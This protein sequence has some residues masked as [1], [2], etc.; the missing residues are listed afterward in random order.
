M[1]TTSNPLDRHATHQ[2]LA[3]NTNTPACGVGSL[4]FYNELVVGYAGT[5]DSGNTYT[6]G[7]GYGNAVTLKVSTILD[8]GVEDKYLGRTQTG[9]NAIFT[10]NNADP[11][12][13]GIA[14]FR[15]AT[16]PLP[17]TNTNLL[18]SFNAV[19]YGNEAIDDGDYFIERG[20][21]YVIQEYR[22]MHINNTDNITFTWK[23]RSTLS[24]LISPILIQ[25]YNFSTGL[26]ETL[27]NQ[28]LTPADIDSQVTVTQSTNVA[29]Y[30]DATNM[31]TFR[32]YQQVN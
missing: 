4:N 2:S 23:G 13:G 20:A 15:T 24:T 7:S 10:I 32:S 11:Y 22:D 25:I 9:Q 8:M 3:T 31:V 5:L 16:Y 30:Y 12:V 21:R 19:N 26:W 6:P 14:T 29:N 18:N 27:A 1:L 28:T 17:P